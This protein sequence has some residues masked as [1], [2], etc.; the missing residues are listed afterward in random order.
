MFKDKVNGLQ[1]KI[2][3]GNY[4]DLSPYLLEVKFEYPKLFADGSGRNLAG[5]MI[6]D[7][8]GVFPKI[9]CEFG[10]LTKTQLELIV[11]IID[12]PTQTIKYYDPNKKAYVEMATYPN[13]WSVTDKSVIE[14]DTT[15][16]GFSITFI[17]VS[18]RT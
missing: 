8:I 4:V 11:P 18:K 17:A 2:P 1:A 3:G 12:A 15:N 14:G 10:P 7:F 13:D 5:K 9:T 16:S 6:A